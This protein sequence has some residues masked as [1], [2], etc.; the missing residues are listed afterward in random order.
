MMPRTKLCK[1]KVTHKFVFKFSLRQRSKN[2]ILNIPY[3]GKR[4]SS[5]QVLHQHLSS[6]P[7]TKSP[8]IYQQTLSFFPSTPFLPVQL[9]FHPLLRPLP[10][11]T[12]IAPMLFLLLVSP[13]SAASLQT[14]V[15]TM[16][17]VIVIKW[18]PNHVCLPLWFHFSL[19]KKSSKLI[20]GESLFTV[21]TP[22]RMG[23]WELRQHLSLRSPRLHTD[24][25]LCLQPPS[26]SASHPV[27]SLVRHDFK[28][29][30]VSL[31]DILLPSYISL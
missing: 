23:F 26:G 24:G 6:V 8:D 27:L 2:S 20:I 4:Y 13:K 15:C 10:S 1:E 28:A 18:K 22:T 5:N 17:S 3:F 19:M 14:I 7:L 11:L 31:G 30:A 25:A 29:R 9:I 12:S 16:L 21:S